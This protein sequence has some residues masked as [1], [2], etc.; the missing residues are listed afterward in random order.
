M[1]GTGARA[2]LRCPPDS[3]TVGTT[4]VNRYEASVWS[5]PPTSTALIKAVRKGKATLADLTAGGATQLGAADDDP[6]TLTEYP[7][8]FPL[9]G[10]WTV[11]LYAVSVP[12]VLPS[13]C[14]SWFQA[15]QACA[16][17]GGRLLTNQEWQRAA[18]GT[19]APDTDN[20]TTDCNTGSPGTPAFLPSLT[21]ARLDCVSSW[22]VFDMV[23]NLEEWVA[24]W[25][26]SSFSCT[27]WPP[28]FGNDYTCLGG[29]SPS[30]PGALVRG[31]SYPRGAGAGVFT[32]ANET[33]DYN[34]QNEFGFRCAR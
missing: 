30:F 3:A 28:L 34:D 15:E 26:E 32:L 6:C 22:G 27:F 9:N 2:E 14:I 10:N 5:I 12:G 33:P 24:D 8:T 20:G 1:R 4:C 31:G 16:L 13:A 23:G 7:D 25:V 21:G 17:S 29:G 19:P 11:P 18:A